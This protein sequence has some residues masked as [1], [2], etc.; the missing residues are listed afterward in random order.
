MKFV[1]HFHV[2]FWKGD[3]Q[4]EEHEITFCFL[5]KTFEICERK[6]EKSFNT[7]VPTTKHCLHQPWR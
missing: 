3:E 4:E 1:C 2:T 6:K 5:M 7:R